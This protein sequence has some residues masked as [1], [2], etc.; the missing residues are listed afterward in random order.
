MAPGD[1]P[2]RPQEDGVTAFAFF[3]PRPM[4]TDLTKGGMGDVARKMCPSCPPK[5]VGQ[6]DRCTTG[7]MIF[8]TNGR[9]TCH[10]NAHVAKSYRAWYEGWICS[11]G[12]CNGEL[13]DVQLTDLLAGIELSRDDG[14]ARF[15]SV[16]RCEGEE[17]D[18]VRLPSGELLRKFLYSAVVSIRCGKF[19]VVKRLFSSVGKG[20]VRLQRLS[21]AGLTPSTPKSR[22]SNSQLTTKQQ[23]N[24]NKT[25]SKETTTTKQQAKHNNLCIWKTLSRVHYFPMVNSTS[26]NRNSTT[27]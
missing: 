27:R 21:V 1:E 5:P 13:T 23:Q 12:R 16:E 2:D 11:D 20:V 9:L 18:P 4:I 15:E 24:N 17:M 7:L 3:K 6:L 26:N 10:L 22:D 25:A 8:T 14:R 19:H